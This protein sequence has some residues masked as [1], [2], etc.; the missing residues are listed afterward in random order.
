MTALFSTPKMPKPKPV[1][2]AA[3][4]APPAPPTTPAET[5]AGEVAFLRGRKR[6]K[7]LAGLI[8]APLG[9]GANKTMPQANKTTLGA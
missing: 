7:G 2:V 8:L 4:A 5:N 9:S 6:G 3:P 1:N